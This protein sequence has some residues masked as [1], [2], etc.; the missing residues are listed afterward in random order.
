MAGRRQLEA[1]PPSDAPLWLLQPGGLRLEH[2]NNT[3]KQDTQQ[4]STSVRINLNI[5]GGNTLVHIL[6]TYVHICTMMCVFF[7]SPP[8]NNSEVQPTIKGQGRAV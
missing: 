6:R 7:H 4:W 5:G 1:P 2:E 8:K 3:T